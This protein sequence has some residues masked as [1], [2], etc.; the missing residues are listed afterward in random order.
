MKLEYWLPAESYHRDIFLSQTRPR[1]IWDRSNLLRPWRFRVRGAYLP[2]GVIRASDTLQIRI[3]LANES[4]Q[5]G[6][7][8]IV[9]SL[10]E[11][12][13]PHRLV[14][15]SNDHSSRASHFACIASGDNHRLGIQIPWRDLVRGL[16][17]GR[18]RHTLA[19]ELEISTPA[20]GRQPAGYIPEG[21]LAS[22]SFHRV[23]LNHNPIA[24]LDQPTANV[25]ISY[26]WRGREGL[27]ANVHQQWAYRFADALS[28]AGVRPVIDFNFLSPTLV[29]KD[30][31]RKEIEQADRVII[32]YSDQFVTRM[33]DPSTGVGYEYD[34][35][36]S[37]GSFWAKTVPIR[38]DLRQ[39]A[40]TLFAIDGRFVYDFEATGIE[41]ATLNLLNLM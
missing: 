24:V 25:F 35:L 30:T 3:D 32:I 23:Q 34:L 40:D 22:N 20:H 33:N 4:R 27:G 17:P 9:A 29:T 19:V 26:A 37:N 7:V 1:R 41:T 16:P 31:I 10:R 38:R 8:Y 14:Y 2:R 18:S 36:R 13:P 11:V 21:E 5:E 6:T 28:Q 15:C 39:K 12:Y